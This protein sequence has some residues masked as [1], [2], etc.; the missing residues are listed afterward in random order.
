MIDTV[1]R[2]RRPDLDFPEFR[3]KEGRHKIHD[4][5]AMLHYK[6]VEYLLKEFGQESEVLYDP[7][8]GSGV[9]LVEG[10]KQNK[11][12]IG[13]DI[14]PLAL[15]IADVR[16]Q[17]FAVEE[18]KNVL[19]TIRK[20][21]L[22]SKP[23]IPKVKNIEYWFKE[24]VIEDL[25]KLRNVLKSFMSDKIFKFLLVVF[26]QTVRNVSNNRKGE[27]KRYRIEPSK[28]SNYNPNVWN[29]FEKIFCEYAESYKG[30]Y[31]PSSVTKKLLL[32]DVRKPLDFSADIVITSPPYGDSRTTVAYGEFSSFSLEWLKDLNPY[33]DSKIDIDKLS[34]GGNNPKESISQEVSSYVAELIKLLERLDEKR[35][36]SV[37]AYFNDLFLACQNIARVV[38]RGGTIIFVVGNRKVKGIQIQTDLAVK[39][40]FEYL[41]CSHIATFVRKIS[42]KRMPVVNSPTN[43]VGQTQ[44]TMSEE[45]I[46]IMRKEN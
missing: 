32:M 30:D 19:P 2:I 13:T 10:L 33:G 36:K 17:N 11:N 26:S 35:A 8:C 16:T 40:F 42:N 29:E 39:E 27:F 23:D 24:S 12:V 45:F 20:M 37:L 44:E 14:N 5:P 6:V 15:L 22:E 25:G 43:K 46:V 28:L 4:Y 18:L 34:L 31:L 7:F 1:L 38:N 21:F 41:G 3:A 9:S